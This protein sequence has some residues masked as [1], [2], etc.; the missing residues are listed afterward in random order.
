MDRTSMKKS[1]AKWVGRAVFGTGALAAIAFAYVAGNWVSRALGIASQAHALVADVEDTMGHPFES[2]QQ[3]VDNLARALDENDRLKLENAHLKLR[4][5]GLQFDCQQKHAEAKTRT[6]EHELDPATG[7]KVGRTLS[8]IAYRI[9]DQLA[10]DQLYVL[11][12]GYLKAGE[13]EKAAS[14]L[15]FLA[16][17]EDQETFKNPKNWLMTGVAW[18]RL[19]NFEAAEPY[20]DKV[21]QGA[22]HEEAFQTYHA[23]ALLWKALINERLGKKTKAQF[24][25]RELIDHHPYSREAAWVNARNARQP[26]SAGK[27]SAHHKRGT[28]HAAAHPTHR[29]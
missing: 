3:K 17:L 21:I 8:S 2:L 16:N 4:V 9:P 12:V 10:P 1:A 22:G 25:L 19:D 26:A 13:N 24:W 27:H 20:F 28:E 11:G 18:Y 15:T 14:I 29:S 6:Y 23:Q 7:T 5:E